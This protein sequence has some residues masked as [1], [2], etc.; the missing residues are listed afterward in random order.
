MAAGSPG[1]ILTVTGSDFAPTAVV[2]WNGAIRPTTFVSPTRITAS[3][4]AADIAAGGFASVTVANAPGAAPSNPLSFAIT[5]GRAAPV[6]VA[7]TATGIFCFQYSGP[8]TTA[9]NFGS[10][11]TTAVTAVNKLNFPDGSYSSWFPAA[12]DL[13][14]ISSIADGAVLCVAAPIGTLV[15]V[16]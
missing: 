13:A 11:F 8:T 15:F 1:F 7:S 10:L 14:T 9:A 3:I 12:P 6:R 2:E 5:R 4:P 16:S